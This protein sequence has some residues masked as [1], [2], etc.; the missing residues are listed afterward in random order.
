MPQLRY[1]TTDAA[2]N[3]ALTGELRRAGGG[4]KAKSKAQFCSI[5][6]L[7]VMVWFGS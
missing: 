4:Q 6:S 7:I 2:V 1:A 3:P 5:I